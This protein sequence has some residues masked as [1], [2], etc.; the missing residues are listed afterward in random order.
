M[1]GRF[2]ITG[3][4]LTCLFGAGVVTLLLQAFLRFHSRLV[5]AYLIAVIGGKLQ[6]VEAVYLAQ[7]GHLRGSLVDF[8]Q[9]SPLDPQR[10]VLYAEKIHS[11]HS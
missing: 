7:D 8:V 4:F 9:P 11:F 6:G 10:V 2:W 3:A 5:L 1:I